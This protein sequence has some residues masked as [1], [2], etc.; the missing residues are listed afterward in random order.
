[1]NT[2][3]IDTN[4]LK[5]MFNTSPEW[6][7]DGHITHLITCWI[8]NKIE[9][10]MDTKGRILGE[11][12]HQ[13]GSEIRRSDETGNERIYLNW[14]LTKA[15]EAGRQIEVNLGD[16]LG[17]CISSNIRGGERSD[18]VFVYVA[19]AIGCHL[20]SNNPRHINNQRGELRKCARRHGAGVI[21]IYSSREALTAVTTA[22]ATH[23]PP[24]A[25]APAA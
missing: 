1:M 4:I 19:A 7:G 18:Q 11:Y 22:V 16:G 14:I 24:P 23:E 15:R 13:L 2:W 5:H 12:D 8:R 21:E 20:A 10:G 25:A 9:I 6:N 17:N 3:V